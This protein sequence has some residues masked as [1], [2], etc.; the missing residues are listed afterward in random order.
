MFSSSNVLLRPERV[1]DWLFLI[2]TGRRGDRLTCETVGFEAA[3]IRIGEEVLGNVS[4][5]GG[6]VEVL[7]E[8]EADTCDIWGS[9]GPLLNGLKSQEG[10]NL[11]GSN[12]REVVVWELRVFTELVD[13]VERNDLIDDCEGDVLSEVTDSVLCVLVGGSSGGKSIIVCFGLSSIGSIRGG[14][15]EFR[16]EFLLSLRREVEF[17]VALTAG[18]EFAAVRAA[19]ENFESGLKANTSMSNFSASSFDGCISLVLVA[20]FD[21][22]SGGSGM[23]GTSILERTSSSKS[24]NI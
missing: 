17:A 2:A 24:P 9:L 6:V 5:G 21:G 15:R 7:G 12:P 18:V 23:K 20:S 1:V 14:T 10:A 19:L 3:G 16:F 13:R 22:E 4:A 11:D 8:A